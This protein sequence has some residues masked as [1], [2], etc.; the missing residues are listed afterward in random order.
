ME[1]TAGFSADGVGNPIQCI[2]KTQEVIPEAL[3]RVQH[4]AFAIDAP[5]C[6]V[7]DGLP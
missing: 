2:E 7:G 1:E 5:A 6:G 3:A 4:A